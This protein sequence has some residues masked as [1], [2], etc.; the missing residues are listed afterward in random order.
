MNKN[1]KTY[2]LL[3]A[4][5]I[6][7]GAIGFQVYGYLNPSTSDV[8]PIIGE[9]FIPN[10]EIENVTYNISPDYRDPFFGK[11][12]RKPKPKVKKKKIIQKQKVVF[13]RISYDGVISNDGNKTFLISI[14]GVQEIFT[15]KQSIGGVELIRGNNNEVTL[16]YKGS[17]KKYSLGQ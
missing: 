3:A 8:N 11:I 6:V 14:N 12:Y 15:V 17:T 10:E 16:K 9:R 7:W 2:L 1:Q 4:V 5:I 13:P